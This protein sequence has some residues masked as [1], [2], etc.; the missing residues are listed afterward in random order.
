M[1]MN[2]MYTNARVS[3]LLHSLKTTVAV[4]TSYE[5]YK[6]EIGQQY[7]SFFEL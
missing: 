7:N 5:Y 3:K 4:N 1:H 2:K 6:S